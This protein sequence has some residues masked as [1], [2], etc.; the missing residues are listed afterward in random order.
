MAESQGITKR[1]TK[2]GEEKPATPEYFHRKRARIS[3]LRSDCKTCVSAYNAEHREER[4]A[5]G[6]AYC[7]AHRAE[8]KAAS[9]AY[10]ASH[11]RQRKAY[12]A[13]YNVSERGVAR[14]A[15][16]RAKSPEK[17]RARTAVGNAIRDGVLTRGPCESC[18]LTPRIVNG[19]QRIEAHHHNGYDEDHRLDVVWLCVTCHGAAEAD[20]AA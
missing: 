10:Y 14:D 2:C 15:R 11:R 6:A 18:G 1:C 13:A 8:R 7:A 20:G 16:R 4:Q 5:Y 17:I 19:R 9:A 12:A 3:G